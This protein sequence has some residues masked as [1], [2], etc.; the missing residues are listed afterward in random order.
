MRT[1]TRYQAPESV[2]PTP[3][4]GA[5]ELLD[6]LSD[7]ASGIGLVFVSFLAAI[8]GLFPVVL[9]TAVGGAILL[10]PVLVLGVAIGAVIGIPVL[11]VRLSVRAVA[12]VRRASRRRDRRA[13]RVSE[14]E[15]TG[16][17]ALQQADPTAPLA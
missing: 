6:E 11:I 12:F 4:P 15:W 8:P 17:M 2:Q 7:A 16:G 5:T 10:I 13:P 9:L 14:P 1:V 3:A